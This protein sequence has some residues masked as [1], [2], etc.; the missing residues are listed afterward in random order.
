MLLSL[1]LHAACCCLS[2]MNTFSSVVV[3]LL[4]F[5]NVHFILKRNLHRCLQLY[6][7]LFLFYFAYFFNCCY[8]VDRSLV[9]SILLSLTICWIKHLVFYSTLDLNSS[10]FSMLMSS[11]VRLIFL[12]PSL[13]SF[14]I[15]E[16]QK[17]P[18][19]DTEAT[20]AML[21]NYLQTIFK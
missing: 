7:C 16:T 8:L 11:S 20:P 17:K 3:Q 18:C 4:T 21:N 1:N 15:W 13:H 2:R 19:T 9:L 6:F 14:T 12:T 10:V 5:Y